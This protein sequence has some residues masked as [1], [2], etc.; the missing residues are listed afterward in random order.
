M[1]AGLVQIMALQKVA[2]QM[3]EGEKIRAIQHN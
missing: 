1:L 3:G 2:L